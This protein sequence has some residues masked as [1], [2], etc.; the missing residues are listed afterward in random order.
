MCV[1][2]EICAYVRGCKDK[3]F[4]IG[5][6]A[7][8]FGRRRE[9][10]ITALRAYGLMDENEQYIEPVRLTGLEDAMEKRKINY[11]SFQWSPKRQKT[12]TEFYQEGATVQ[13]IASHFGTD[14][15]TVYK[16]INKYNLVRVTHESSQEA[17]APVTYSIKPTLEKVSPDMAAG[18]KK[19]LQRLRHLGGYANSLQ[20]DAVRLFLDDRCHEAFYALGKQELILNELNGI[21]A[22]LIKS[23]P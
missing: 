22:D 19:R 3:V 6:A 15:D 9:Q 11:P 2:G 7:T 16:A 8:I 14:E 23:E 18:E 5:M 21:I 1:D 10:V 4:A 20:K 17:D 13:D 12:L